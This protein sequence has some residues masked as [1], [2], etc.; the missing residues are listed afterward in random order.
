MPSSLVCQIERAISA[1]E[2]PHGLEADKC[3]RHIVETA[4]EIKPSV[5][6]LFCK[7]LHYEDIAGIQSVR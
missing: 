5:D 4:Y 6:L 1:Q 2:G 3:H 7:S